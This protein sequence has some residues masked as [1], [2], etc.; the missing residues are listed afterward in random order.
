MYKLKNHHMNDSGQTS[1]GVIQK[2]AIMTVTGFNISH[3]TNRLSN[4]YLY[5]YA[6]CNMLVILVL[7]RGNS[8]QM[9]YLS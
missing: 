4:K 2:D 7:W 3:A 9:N 1:I 5:F 6:I 8:T